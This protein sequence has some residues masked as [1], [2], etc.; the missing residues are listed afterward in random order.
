MYC[1][2]LLF[3]GATADK[4]KNTT[5]QMEKSTKSKS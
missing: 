5:S 4:L 1:L 3:L 2:E